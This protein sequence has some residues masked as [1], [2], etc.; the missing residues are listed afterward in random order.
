MTLNRQVFPEDPLCFARG[1]ARKNRRILHELARNF[2][3]RF[4]DTEWIIPE[5]FFTDGASIPR[6]AY[7]IAGGPYS[8]SYVYAAFLHDWLYSVH[9]RD[10]LKKLAHLKHHETSWDIALYERSR[11]INRQSADYL[12]YQLMMETGQ[13]RYRARYFYTAVR[14]NILYQWREDA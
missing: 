8:D 14:A 2:V 13:P 7:S 4:N 9:A 11:P 3:V 10:W 1:E 5:G 12:L 6:I